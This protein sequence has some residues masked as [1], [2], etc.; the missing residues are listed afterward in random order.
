[1]VWKIIGGDLPKLKEDIKDILKK[2]K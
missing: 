2:E 1:M